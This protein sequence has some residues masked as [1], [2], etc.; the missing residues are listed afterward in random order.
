[1]DYYDE[2]EYGMSEDNREQELYDFLQSD[3]FD[4]P[5]DPEERDYALTETVDEFVHAMPIGRRR[6]IVVHRRY[7]GGRVY[8][9]MRTWN[10]HQKSGHWYPTKRYFVLPLQYGQYFHLVLRAATEGYGFSKPK[11]LMQREAEEQNALQQARRLASQG[12]IS[13]DALQ[14]IEKD[15]RAYQRGRA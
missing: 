8:L 5:P 15:T 2:N 9:R 1:M 10:K 6:T 3:D 11:W 4:L 14:T 12:K 13:A 7:H